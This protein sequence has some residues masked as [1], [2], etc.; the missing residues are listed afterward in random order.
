MTTI[1]AQHAIPNTTIDYDG[2]TI[3]VSTV[4][5]HVEPGFVWL[6]GVP[7]SVGRTRHYRLARHEHLLLHL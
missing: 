5:P 3:A 6:T 1:E 4:E 7:V 2:D